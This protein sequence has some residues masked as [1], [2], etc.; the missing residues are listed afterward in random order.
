MTD[1]LPRAAQKVQE[2]LDRFGV[3][4]KVSI[5]AESTRTAQEAADAVGCQVAQIV[6]S[7]VMI[8][9]QSGKPYLVVASGKNRVDLKKVSALAGE[10][11]KM[12][13]AEFVRECT[14]YAIGGVPPAGHA[15]ELPTIIDRDLMEYPLIWAAAGTPHALFSL[16]PDDLRKIT[17]GRL[18]DTK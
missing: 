11:V 13:P 15:T 9:K 17:G 5:M 4:L 7:L 2:A 6:K 3:S 12:A 10:G 16:T 1:G 8:G 18:A 14:G